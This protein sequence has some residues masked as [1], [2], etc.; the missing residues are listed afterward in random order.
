MGTDL[1][2]CRMR[3][4]TVSREMHLKRNTSSTGLRRETSSKQ[5]FHHD[6]RMLVPMKAACQ[7]G[8]REDSKLPPDQEQS[9]M[10]E[11]ITARSS[12]GRM[13]TDFRTHGCLCFTPIA[14][15]RGTHKRPEVRKGWC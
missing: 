2:R 4:D 14:K 3:T 15:A 1:D 5:S 13:A 8:R 7:L 6:S 12:S 9:P 11:R 10:L